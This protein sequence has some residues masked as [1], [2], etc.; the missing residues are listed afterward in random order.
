M[1]VTRVWLVVC[2]A[3]VCAGAGLFLLGRATAG[4]EAPGSYARGV[5]D[6]RAAGVRDGRAEQEVRSLPADARKGAREAF[7]DGYLAGADDVFGG[8]DGGWALSQP[9]VITLRAGGAG[10]T[11]RFASRVPLRAGVGYRL[12]PHSFRLCQEPRG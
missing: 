2:L 6:G 11:Y 9:Y 1:R 7:D 10:V 4:G 5:E 12:C 8:Y 3:G